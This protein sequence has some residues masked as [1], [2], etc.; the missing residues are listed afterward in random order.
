VARS[1]GASASGGTAAPLEQLA[2][3]ETAVMLPNTVSVG[4]SWEQAH[5]A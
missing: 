5:S 2:A 3:G 1:N 4:R